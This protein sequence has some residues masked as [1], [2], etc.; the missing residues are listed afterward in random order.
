MKVDQIFDNTTQFMDGF[1]IPYKANNEKELIYKIKNNDEPLCCL[2][3]QYDENIDALASGTIYLT[4]YHNEAK[5]E[6]IL[7]VETDKS[8]SLKQRQQPPLFVII[9]DVSNSMY[10]YTDD[11]QKQ[12]IPKLLY[13]LGYVWEDKD[14]YNKLVEKKVTNIELLYA[15]SSK[16]MLDKFLKDYNLQDSINP[17]AL[18]KFCNNIIPLIT[19][20]DGSDFYFYDIHKFEKKSLYGGSTY[21]KKAAYHL[22]MLLNSV[23]RERSIRLLSFSDGDIYDSNKSLKILNKILNSGKTKHQMNSVSVRINHDTQPDTKILMKLSSFSHPI[24]DM[25]QLVINLKEEKNIDEVVDKLYKLFINDDMIYNLKITSDLIFMSNDFSSSAFSHEQYFNRKNQCLR[26]NKHLENINEY[27]SIL[28]LPFG[29]IIIE[30]GGKLNEHNFYNIMSNNASNLAQRI[31]ERKVN[32]SNNLKQNQE[33]IDYLKEIEKNFNNKTKLYKFFEEINNNPEIYKMNNNELS[34]YISKV[35]DEAKEIIKINTNLEKKNNDDKDRLIKDLEDTINLKKDEIRKEKIDNLNKEEKINILN[36]ENNK[37]KKDNDILKAYYKEL[38][39][40]YYR[41]EESSIKVS[42]DKNE[43]EKEKTKL[44]EDI[45]KINALNF[46]LNN[47]YNNILNE[48]NNLKEENK[49]LNNISKNKELEMNKLKEDYIR[50]RDNY[51]KLNNDYQLSKKN[52]VYRE[53]YEK[54]KKSNDA[55]INN[56]KKEREDFVIKEQ[57]LKLE[58][59]NL[60]SKLKELLCKSITVQLNVEELKEKNIKLKAENDLLKGGFSIF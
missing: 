24:C 2:M 57:N 45:N 42:N 32:Q 38:Y 31:L 43:L 44:R 7:L 39:N 15:I 1:G 28:K 30:E 56:L 33:I 18:K 58:N 36:N 47:D 37:I 41:L 27:Q 51:D 55:L 20:S 29:K 49:N 46:N 60:K 48:N 11:L 13:K 50:L 14:F 40:E 17:E 52:E 9:L 34:E 59:E 16:I 19:F 21:F 12:I 26:I 10:N 25:T 8:G 23:S 6:D 54:L 5:N 35:K 4:R 3:N 22:K 53:Y